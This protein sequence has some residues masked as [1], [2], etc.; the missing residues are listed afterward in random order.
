MGRSYPL[1]DKASSLPRLDRLLAQPLP[2][3]VRANA[4]RPGPPPDAR[5]HPVG[6]LRLILVLEGRKEEIFAEDGQV[7]HWAM[8]AGDVLVVRP[9]TWLAPL[10]HTRH[11]HLG[12][13][14][15]RDHLRVAWCRCE[16]RP[17][18]PQPLETEDWFELAAPERSALRQAAN[19]LCALEPTA[20]QEAARHLIATCLH[21]LRTA[22]ARPQEPH[23]KGERT[24]RQALVW[25]HDN[26]HL[27]I[28]REQAAR[29]LEVSPNYLSRLCRERGGNSFI[30]LLNG[31]RLERAAAM[32]RTVDV[33]VSQV[34][35]ACGFSDAGYFIRRFRRGFGVTPGA[36]RS[37]LREAV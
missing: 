8:A 11:R 12:I 4:M 15:G 28:G 14:F 35:Q 30:D 24:W 21:L 3:Q 16:G 32:L 5:V 33:P 36:Y 22:A 19:A 20:D 34:A 29:A 26:S 9:D 10:F 17:R 27:P 31:L 13:I 2:R 25:L 18:L 6:E 37:S 23:A 1:M 7:A